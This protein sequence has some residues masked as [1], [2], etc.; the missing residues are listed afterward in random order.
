MRLMGQ[1]DNGINPD[2][3][4]RFIGKSGQIV[5]IYFNFS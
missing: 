1:W 5:M 3:L 2:H 4:S